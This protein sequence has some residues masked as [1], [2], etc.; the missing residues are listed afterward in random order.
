MIPIIQSV[1]T[2]LQTRKGKLRRYKKFVLEVMKSLLGEADC[3][4]LSKDDVRATRPEI[5]KYLDKQVN[6]TC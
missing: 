4:F 2:Y 6:R 3:G 1:R 5:N